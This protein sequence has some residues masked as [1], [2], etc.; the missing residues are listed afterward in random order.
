MGST[1]S[2]RISAPQMKSLGYVPKEYFSPSSISLGRRCKRRWAFRYIEGI[3]E[4]EIDYAYFTTPEAEA[5]VKTLPEMLRMLWY[6]MRSK[7]LGKAVHAKL[8]RYFLKR[9]VRWS[10]GPGQIARAMADMLPHPDECEEIQTEHE[11][12]ID[13]SFYGGGIEPIVFSGVADLFVKVGGYWRLYDYKSTKSLTNKFEEV[14]YNYV[15]TVD[16]L[17]EDEQAGLYSLHAMQKAKV[18]NIE[19]EW[20]Y[21]LTKGKAKAASTKFTMGRGRSERLV[22]ALIKDADHLRSIIRSGKKA[23]DLEGNPEACSDF[24]RTCE[25]HITNGG[26]CAVK[27][28]LGTQLVQI[29]KKEESKAMAKSFTEQL[30]DA[31]KEA[32]SKATKSAAAKSKAKA[33]K[34]DEEEEEEEDEAEEEEE[35]EEEKPAKAAKK[36]AKKA[37]PKGKAK[38]DSEVE[39]AEVATATIMSGGVTITISADLTEAEAVA[40]IADKISEEI[41]A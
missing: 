17:R 3:K 16:E 40:A 23:M 2:A 5:E 28:S 7:A 12:T 29:R 19:C 14:G 36:T 21:G 35:E 39:R 37:A 38:A 25:H 18:D 22:R 4:P 9:K 20:V 8:E 32:G 33:P 6:S 31:K 24:G 27:Q 11:I 15:K 1:V 41:F 13:C 26:P 34:D 10:D 30:K